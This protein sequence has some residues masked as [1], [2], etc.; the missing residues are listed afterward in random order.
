[1]P[2]RVKFD[3]IITLVGKYYRINQ[4]IQAK[5]VRVIG[6]DGKQI[7]VMPIFNAVQ[8]ARKLGIDL[9]EVAANAKPPVCKLIQF[10]KFLYQEAKKEREAR[11]ARKTGGLK[12]IRL[13]PFIA[14]NDFDFR[15]RRAKELIEEGNK[16]KIS[17][18]FQGR[19]L[20][21]KE[22]GQE[23]LSRAIAE[24]ESVAKKDAEPKWMGKDFFI[25]MT[26]SA[27]KPT[28]KE[29]KNEQNED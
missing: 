20:G 25:I 17:V 14:K 15:I 19:Q 8:E 4:Y 23:V 27:I 12:E 24:M 21:H 16:V 5:E 9:V 22:F 11:K 6:E 29:D 28:K 1:M 3:K 26:P 13:S 10:K 2:R 7:G 18:R